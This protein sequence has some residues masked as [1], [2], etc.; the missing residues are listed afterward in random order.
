M[1]LTFFSVLDAKNIFP[2]P[3]GG[4]CTTSTQNRNFLPILLLFRL[5][6]GK[7]L[8]KYYFLKLQ[9]KFLYGETYATELRKL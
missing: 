3:A 8:K 4:N 7:L 5:I 2:V 1:F 9:C 6:F